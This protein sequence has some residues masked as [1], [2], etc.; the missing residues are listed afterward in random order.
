MKKEIAQ[1]YENVSPDLKTLWDVELDLLA[2]FKA[3]CEKHHLRW[4]ADGGTLLGAVRHSGFIPWDDDVDIIMPYDD[5][6]KLC[7]LS[8]EFEEPYFLQTWKTNEG[9]RPFLSRLRRSDTTGYTYR[10]S[11]CPENW[12]KGIFIDI[13]ALCYIPDNFIVSR[14]QNILL[15]SIRT[16]YFGYQ[17]KRDGF[18][19]ADNKYLDYF[20]KTTYTV[21]NAVGK[22]KGLS[23]LMDTYVRLGGWQKE[24][25]KYCAPLLFRPYFK[26]LI[27]K[28]EWYKETVM[29]DFMDMTVPCPKDYD[30]RLKSQ[31]GDY[32]TPVKAPTN[33]GGITYDTNHSYKESIK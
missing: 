21:F 17:S 16:V 20:L 3:V 19:A 6:C 26:G 27:W 24:G 12:N 31:Y 9:S 13:F 4:F 23:N 32:M 10:E 22:S 8:D 18:P 29:L 15:K 5:Y 14:T 2:K 30:S 7:S 11:F 25:S 1:Q 28:T 33:H